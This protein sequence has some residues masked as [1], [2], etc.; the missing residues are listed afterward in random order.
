MVE[1]WKRKCVTSCGMPPMKKQASGNL[2][3]EIAALFRGLGWDEEIP[4]LR[5]YQIK[6]ITF[7]P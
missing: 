2:G 5:G 1:A 7:K 3:S 6:P 4:E